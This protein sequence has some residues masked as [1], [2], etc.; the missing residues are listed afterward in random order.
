VPRDIRRLEEA[1]SETLGMEARVHMS[2][3]GG[4]LTLGFSDAE[5]LQGMLEKLGIVM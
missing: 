2:R 3:N 4:R 1:L 5:Q